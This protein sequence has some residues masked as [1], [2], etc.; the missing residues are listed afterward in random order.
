MRTQDVDFF[1]PH[2]N[3]VRYGGSGVETGQ[4]AD[5]RDAD[6]DGGKKTVRLVGEFQCLPGG[7]VAFFGLCFQTRL[8]RG[9]HGDFRHGEHSVQQDETQYDNNLHIKVISF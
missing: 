1:Y 5:E 2:P 6:L 3:V 8:A 7:L 9:D 4:Y